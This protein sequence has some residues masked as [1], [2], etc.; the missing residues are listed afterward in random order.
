MN[1]EIAVALLAAAAGVGA[2]RA[3]M[4]VENVEGG[5]ITDGPRLTPTIRRRIAAARRTP[6]AFAS[7]RNLTQQ[8]R[9]T[10]VT[11]ALP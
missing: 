9:A 7:M 1:E 6:P 5:R 2:T 8:D 4:D 10:L 3:L 11:A